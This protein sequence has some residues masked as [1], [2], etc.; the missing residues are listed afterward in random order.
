MARLIVKIRRH[1]GRACAGAYVSVLA[2]TRGAVVQP[3]PPGVALVVDGTDLQR[4]RECGSRGGHG[5]PEQSQT[6]SP[7]SR[8]STRL[9]MLKSP[10]RKAQAAQ[11]GRGGCRCDHG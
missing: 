2:G 3:L 4:V 5:R 9:P 11:T 10:A 1:G 6:S 7:S 8:C